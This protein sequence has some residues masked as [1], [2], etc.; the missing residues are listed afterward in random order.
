[1]TRRAGRSPWL[2][3]TAWLGGGLL[4]LGSAACKP[5]L[6]VEPDLPPGVRIFLTLAGT[7]RYTATDVRLAGSSGPAPCRIDGVTLQLEQRRGERT[8]RPIGA[9]TGRSQGGQLTCAGNLA[10]LSGPV[11]SFPVDSGYT[12][13]EFVA[14]DIGS[15]T[16]RHDGRVSTHDSVR[17]DS[18]WGA[19]TLNSGGI[20]LNGLFSAVPV[21][22]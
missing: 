9:F 12:F 7:W 14:F 2:A 8:G 10:F 22:R 6:G 15:P 16:W 18:M 3:V 13:N 19:F 17:V 21:K 4:L 1:M 11:S 5:D 20:E